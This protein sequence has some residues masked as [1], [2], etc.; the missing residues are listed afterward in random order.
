M[1]GSSTYTVTINDIL[2]NSE[3]FLTSTPRIISND[4]QPHLM[5]NGDIDTFWLSSSLSAFFTYDFGKSEVINRYRFICTEINGRPFDWTVQMSNDNSTWVTIDTQIGA[6][7]TQNVYAT[8]NLSTNAFAG[9]YVR[10]VITDSTNSTD[11]HISEMEFYKNADNRITISSDLTG[12]DGIF[13]LDFF[14]GTQRVGHNG[15]EE[16]KFKKNTIGDL[17]GFQPIKLTGFNNYTSLYEV[18][19]DKERQLFL[20]IEGIDNIHTVDKHQGDRF[21]LL[22]LNSEKGDYSFIKNFNNNKDWDDRIDN[23]FV[24]FTDTPM[25]LN[26]LKI[27]YIKPNGNLY[28]FYGIEHSL[29]FRIKRFNFKNQVIQGNKTF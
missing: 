2:R 23:E 1:I 15:S 14:G 4:G 3:V 10:F 9:R 25:N 18:I 22:T 19:L 27:K 26:K 8:F 13:N 6:S 29:H 17:L 5:F 28:N 20:C 12:G 11:V 7:T 24:F 21:V 16:N